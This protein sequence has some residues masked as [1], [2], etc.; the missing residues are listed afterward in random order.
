MRELH[1][2]PARDA[3]VAANGIDNKLHLVRIMTVNL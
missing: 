3:S 1:Y 2:A